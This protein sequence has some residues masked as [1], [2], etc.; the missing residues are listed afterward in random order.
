[1]DFSRDL[2]EHVLEMLRAWRSGGAFEENE[3]A[4]TLMQELVK[5]EALWGKGAGVDNGSGRV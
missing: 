1:M 5:L 4:Q 3:Y 2:L